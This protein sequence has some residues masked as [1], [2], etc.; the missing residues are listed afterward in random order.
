LK[1]R[2]LYDAVLYPEI[3]TQAIHARFIGSFADRR[4]IGERPHVSGG[5]EMLSDHWAI[6]HEFTWNDSMITESSADSCVREKLNLDNGL[7]HMLKAGQ[8]EGI[9]RITR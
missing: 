4:S 6:I 1:G 7:Q 5:M 2:S 3:E 9:G 8:H